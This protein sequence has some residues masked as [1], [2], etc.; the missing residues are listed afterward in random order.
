MESQA[1]WRGTVLREVAAAVG[2]IAVAVVRALTAG[3]QG[4]SQGN[5]QR[6]NEY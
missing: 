3:S 1:T 5:A 6:F 2:V 4:T